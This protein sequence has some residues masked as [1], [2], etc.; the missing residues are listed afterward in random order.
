M[1]RALYTAIVCLVLAGCATYSISR[2]TSSADNVVAAKAW[3]NLKINVGDFKQIDQISGKSCNYKGNI[4][5][6]D[7]ENYA[8]FIRNAFVTELKMGDAYDKNA[9]LVITGTLDKVDNSTTLNIDWTFTV[10]LTSNTGKK[11]TITEYYKSNASVMGTASST[12]GGA[13]TAFIPAVQN[14]VNKMIT[15]IP[16]SMI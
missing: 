5:T 2:Y 10:T 9:P 14:L 3:K 8:T 13:A 11:L 6:I 16:N 1:I 15:E 4:E 7:G 12:C